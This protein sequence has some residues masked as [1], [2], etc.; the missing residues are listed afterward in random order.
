[1]ILYKQLL[2]QGNAGPVTF[3]S[4]RAIYI[5]FLVLF[6]ALLSSYFPSFTFYIYAFHF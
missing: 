1:M 2:H 4:A 5:V 6:A 3:V